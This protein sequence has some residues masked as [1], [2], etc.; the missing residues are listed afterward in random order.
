MVGNE[1]MA[2]GKNEH[3][4]WVYSSAG[5]LSKSTL[6]PLGWRLLIDQPSV[7]MDK[8]LKP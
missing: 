7:D 5:A 4:V 8:D 2:F 3:G 6:T 1:A